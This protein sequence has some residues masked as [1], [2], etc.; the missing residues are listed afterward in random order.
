MLTSMGGTGLRA[1]FERHGLRPRYR[2]SPSEQARA[3]FAQRLRELVAKAIAQGVPK[4]AVADE[5]KAPG[6]ELDEGGRK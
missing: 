2:L 1:G 4:S 6:S 3:E 5:M